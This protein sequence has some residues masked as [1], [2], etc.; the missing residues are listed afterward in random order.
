MYIPSC[1]TNNEFSSFTVVPEISFCP[2][3]GR[4][5]LCSAFIVWYKYTPVSWCCKRT[6]SSRIQKSRSGREHSMIQ[7][8]PE[9]ADPFVFG[10]LVHPTADTSWLCE[11]G[12]LNWACE[13]KKQPACIQESAMG[14]GS[15]GR[16]QRA[17]HASALGIKKRH[18]VTRV[19][20]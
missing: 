7:L 12:L 19:K 14:G 5:Y 17:M 6:P 10:A 4:P 18:H 8:S 3:I 9:S 2:G 13:C 16:G 20:S 11:S 15:G 1:V